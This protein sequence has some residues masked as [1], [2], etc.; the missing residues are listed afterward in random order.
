MKLPKAPY[1]LA[2]I[3]AVAFATALASFAF[4]T[5]FTASTPAMEV[6]LSVVLWSTY[7]VSTMAVT[8]VLFGWAS[9]IRRPV[10]ETHVTASV[11]GLGVL[12]EKL[13]ETRLNGE[14]IDVDGQ[15]WKAYDDATGL[16][17]ALCD[18]N[19]VGDQARAAAAGVLYRETV[20]LFDA[21][22]FAR[23]VE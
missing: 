5:V 11:A 14:F 18:G 3:T 7:V 9:Q 20:R 10:V 6:A 17:N 23:P 22:G 8:K 21:F 19:V 13:E 15:V 2:S 16:R 12:A 1:V 4:R